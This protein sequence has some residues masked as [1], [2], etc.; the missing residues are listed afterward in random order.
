MVSGCPLSLCEL[1]SSHIGESG[2][3]APPECREVCTDLNAN[4]ARETCSA[5]VERSEE[6]SDIEAQKT[7]DVLPPRSL[8]DS[9]T[10]PRSAPTA[11]ETDITS[12]STK[13]DNHTSLENPCRFLTQNQAQVQ[14]VQQT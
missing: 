9:I 5:R 14:L 10:V 6:D 1:P 13:L 8:A 2:S 12:S 4:L 3:R 7:R 11:L